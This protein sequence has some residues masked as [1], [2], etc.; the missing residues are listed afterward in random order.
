MDFNYR[1]YRK[2]K[3]K[4]F[5]EAGAQLRLWNI[6]KLHKDMNKIKLIIPWRVNLA[7]SST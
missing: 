5:Q 2:Q 1:K 4:M 3:E 6:T 7:F